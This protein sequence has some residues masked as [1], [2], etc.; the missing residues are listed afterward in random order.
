MKV[1][2]KTADSTAV[3]TGIMVV[4][5]PGD[6]ISTPVNAPGVHWTIT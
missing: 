4:E 3:E 5:P 1:L 2:R 6:V